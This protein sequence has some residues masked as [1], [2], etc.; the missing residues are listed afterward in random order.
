MDARTL[1]VSGP[2]AAPCALTIRRAAIEEILALRHRILREG[3]PLEAANF[4]GDREE[5]TLHVG[6]FDGLSVAVGCASMMLNRWEGEAAWQL[7]G[8]A[9]DAGVQSL[10]VGKAVLD[11]LTE[12]AL[13]SPQKVRLFW[14][15]A[16]VPA[17]RF[18]AREGWQVMSEEFDIPT[19]GPHRKLM[20]R[21]NPTCSA[22]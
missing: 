15:N 21:L 22:R 3:L 18:Y 4:P 5:T 11:H 10:G 13:A 8:M 16:R 9:T 20:K 1:T 19:A 6:A 14:C 7:R 17:L 2:G 12:L